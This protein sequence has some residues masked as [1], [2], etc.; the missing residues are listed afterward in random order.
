LRLEYLGTVINKNEVHGEVWRR[1]NSG[2]ASA[3]DVGMFP[4]LYGT[5]R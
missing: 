5:K 1:I 4:V 2:N 3:D